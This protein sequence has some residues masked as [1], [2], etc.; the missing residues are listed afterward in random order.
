[1]NEDKI[2]EL[3]GNGKLSY[4]ELIIKASENGIEIGDTALVRGEY[5]EK[6][7]NE[8]CQHALEREIEHS[9]AKNSDIVKKM[10][11]MTRVTSDEDGV[12]GIDEQITKLKADA[13]YLFKEAEK[14]KKTVFSSGMTHTE[15]KSDPDSMDDYDF[16]KKFKKL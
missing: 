10:I 4:D 9:G 2:A 11:D 5:G 14:E 8:R 6:L 3:F 1:M 16:Y 7:H 12:Y 13:P 15:V